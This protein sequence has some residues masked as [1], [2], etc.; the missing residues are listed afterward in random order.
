[1]RLPFSD[2][3]LDSHTLKNLADDDKREFLEFFGVRSDPR[4]SVEVD[5][6]TIIFTYPPLK[7]A[8]L[9]G[10]PLQNNDQKKLTKNG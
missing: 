6:N 10:V 1:M 9:D 3:K 7:D 4:V 5:N 2:K 8:T